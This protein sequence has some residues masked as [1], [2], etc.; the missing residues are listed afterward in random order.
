M[1]STRTKAMK[2][3]IKMSHKN[4]SGL[5][6]RN[7]VQDLVV[8]S[9]APDQATFNKEARTIEAIMITENNVRSIDLRTWTP[10]DDVLL[11][12]NLVRVPKQ[13]PLLDYHNRSSIT[14]MAGSV[15]N[16]RKD[17]GQLRGTIH[18]SETELGETALKLAEEGHLTDVSGGYRL[19]NK[20]ET[21]IR[22]GKSKVVNGRR[23]RANPDMP[24]RI[25]H[26][27]EIKELSLTPIGA[28]S[29]TIM[30]A[31]GNGRNLEEHNIM[32]LTKKERK[33]FDEFLT[34]RGLDYE[35]LTDEQREPLWKDCQAGAEDHGTARTVPPVN[36]DPNSPDLIAHDA[37]VRSEAQKAELVRQDTIRTLAGEDIPQETVEDCIKKGMT[38]DQCQAVFL[39]TIRG[40]NSTPIGSPAIHVHN[41][42]MA[43]TDLEAALILRGGMQD[44]AKDAYDEETLDRA[45]KHRSISLIDVCVRA[46]AIDQ[47]QIP[48][49]RDEMIRAAVSTMSLPQVLGAVAH[50]A[51]LKGYIYGPDTWRK[52][53]SIGSMSDFKLHTRTKITSAGDLEEV[54][55]AGEVA[56][57]TATEQY[58]RYS[59][60]TYAKQFG[61]TRRDFYND[62]LNQLTKIPQMY[63]RKAKLLLS[64]L[65]YTHLLAN[66]NMTDGVA[67]FH[68]DH[69]NLNTS[70]ALAGSAMEKALYTFMQQTDDDGQVIQVRPKYLI[71]PVELLFTARRLMESEL[72]IA[73]GT[74]DLVKPNKNVLKGMA[75]VIGEERLSN[76][77]YTGYSA[78]TWYM[79]GDPNEVDTIEVGFLNGKDS[80]TIERFAPTA[81]YLGMKSRVLIDAGCKALD[82]RG[83]AKNTA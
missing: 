82:H 67:L 4:K 33:Q 10:V 3:K 71:V 34:V 6:V 23:I 52:W 2:M 74:T 49:S 12:D 30:R 31:D 70:N 68:A 63:G 5:I 13:I 32:K 9:L 14:K 28:D 39:R 27:W 8:R 37:Q 75:E 24:T 69:S 18:L 40:L 66:G 48:Q 29:N 60:L 36:Q 35:E 65:V 64:K 51:A 7:D 43:R 38:V 1:K 56:H 53:C 26:G 77:T 57:G 11:M 54:N 19:A 78:T 15:R 47:V 46:L 55:S 83:M 25:P 45:D 80:P 72:D 61:I 50:K 42:E 17:N 16:I 79:S 76:S 22:A 20:G 59:I 44:M 41:D 21:I 58:E 62:D 73:T 81:D